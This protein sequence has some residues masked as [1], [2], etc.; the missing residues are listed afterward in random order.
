[1]DQINSTPFALG[2]RMPA[3]FDEHA[4]TLVTFPPIEEGI[5]TDIGGFRDEIEAIVR[6]IARFEQVTLIADPADFAEATTRVG[7]VADVVEIPV[8]LCWI[9]DNGPIFVRNEAGELAG[10]HFG[11]NGWG[12][13]FSCD[14]TREMPAKLLDLLG[15]TRFSTPFIGEGGGMS[16][17]GL[18]TLITTEQNMRNDNR[19][20]GISRDEVERHLH[21]YLGIETVIW[22]PLGLREDDATDG[23]VDNVVEFVAPGKVLVQTMPDK[24]N[25]NYE[26]LK[27]NLEILKTARDALGRQL[28]IIEMDVLPYATVRDKRMAIPYTN[29]YVLNGAM[30]APEV[31]PKLDDR[32]FKILEEAYPGRE[33]VTC[34]SEWQALAGGG[35][36]CVTQQIPASKTKGA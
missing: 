26:L 4:Q 22:L 14:K 35:I 31:D 29:A 17:D 19:Y 12:G 2:Y 30:V 34:R 1:M 25:P 23:H 24:A 27:E 21:D 15:I 32:G 5:A 9:R 3:R 8:D 33:L 13:R 11:F 7:D 36:G 16:V 18:G 6:G 20:A 10:V 28:D